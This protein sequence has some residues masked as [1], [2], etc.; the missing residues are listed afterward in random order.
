[1]GVWR[2]H[3]ISTVARI[4]TLGLKNLVCRVGYVNNSPSTL[5]VKTSFYGYSVLLL[6][7]IPTGHIMRKPK[8]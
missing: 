6:Q 4:S 3:D 1:M 8:S 7:I 5:P 2:F